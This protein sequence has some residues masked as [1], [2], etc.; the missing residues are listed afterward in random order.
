MPTKTSFQCRHLADFTKKPHGTLTHEVLIIFLINYLILINYR[1]ENMDNQNEDNN[2][3]DKNSNPQANVTDFSN[4]KIPKFY[5]MAMWPVS[6]PNLNS[7]FST[8][9]KQA[10][11][12]HLLIEL[13]LI[14]NFLVNLS[15]IKATKGVDWWH[16]SFDANPQKLKFLS[17][18]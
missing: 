18:H 13:L 16:P 10:R 2:F 11:L 17:Q 14:R 5:N 6:R 12:K 8:T 7:N 15:T 4:N 1:L 9:Q 3:N